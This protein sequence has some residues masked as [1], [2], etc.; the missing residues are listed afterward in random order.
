METRS[1]TALLPDG[2]PAAAT[3]VVELGYR[4]REFSGFAEQDG[5]RT[6]AGELRRALAT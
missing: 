5:Q 3:L 6:V 1:E 2:T 4:G